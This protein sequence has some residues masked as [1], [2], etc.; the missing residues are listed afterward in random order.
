MLSFNPTLKLE[1]ELKL[2][3]S[4]IVTA[5]Q[6]LENIGFDEKNYLHKFAFISNIGA[7]TRIEN[8][9][10]TDNEI[11]WMDMILCFSFKVSTCCRKIS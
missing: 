11:E 1:K 6:L 7:S 8:A 3:H 9:I 5:N 4:K 2:L 10:L